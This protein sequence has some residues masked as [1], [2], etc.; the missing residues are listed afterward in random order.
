MSSTSSNLKSLEELDFLKIS[1]LKIHFLDL[2]RL[3]MTL[4]VR[5]VSTI[6]SFLGHTLGDNGFMTPSPT[7]CVTKGICAQQLTCRV[8]YCLCAME[9]FGQSSYSLSLPLVPC[10][11]HTAEEQL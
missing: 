4:C 1:L 11:G 3:N 7:L 8:L 9:N 2:R 5:V 6:I 10:Y